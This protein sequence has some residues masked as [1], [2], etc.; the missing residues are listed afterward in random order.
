VSW[1]LDTF[2]EL[3][4]Q[5]SVLRLLSGERAAVGSNALQSFLVQVDITQI[6]IHKA[7]EPDTAVDFLDANGLA[8]ERCAEI[9]LLARP[10]DPSFAQF[11]LRNTTKWLIV[12]P[13]TAPMKTS[14]GKCAWSG[15]RVRATNAAA[16]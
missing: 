14:E 9:D 8:S 6:I 7:D 16:L 3:F 5:D 15:T 1:T 13:K 11:C 4:N 12:Y 2:L 10:Y